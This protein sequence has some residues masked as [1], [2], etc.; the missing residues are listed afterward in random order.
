MTLGIYGSGG[1]GRETLE[2]ANLLDQ[3]EEIIFIDDTN[4]RVFFRGIKTIPFTQFTKEYEPESA[5]VI[6][7]IGEPLV[8]D[9]LYCKVKRFGYSFANIIHPKSHISSSAKLGQGVLIQE[10]VY[11]GCDVVLSDNVCVEHSFP[12]KY[13]HAQ[14]KHRVLHIHYLT[15]PDRKSVV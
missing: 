4:N 9:T 5:E 6:I 2:L 12:L 15:E 14:Q 3:W 7:A 10:N 1:V 8:R 13:S 11:I